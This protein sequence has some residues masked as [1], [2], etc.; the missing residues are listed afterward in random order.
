VKRTALVA[1]HATDFA[2]GA[3]RTELPARF[4]GPAGRSLGGAWLAL[5]SALA[6]HVVDEACHD[7]LSFYNPIVTALRAR[8]PFLPLPTFT[9]SVWIAGLGLAVGL[10]L[11]LTPLAFRGRRW[12]RRLSFPFAALMAAN[13]LTHLVGSIIFHRLVPGFWSSPLLLAASAWLFLAAFAGRAKIDATD[14]VTSA[15]HGGLSPRPPP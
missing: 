5:T 14:S 8:L 3:A 1:A 7:F 2:T 12:M 10:L 9:F 4:A 11:A 13:G 15:A 6:L